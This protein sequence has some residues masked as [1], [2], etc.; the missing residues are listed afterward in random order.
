MTV[1]LEWTQH[2]SHT[3]PQASDAVVTDPSVTA[4]ATVYHNEA[5]HILQNTTARRFLLN[6]KQTETKQHW[7]G[8]RMQGKLACLD[9]ADHSASHSMYKNAAVGE[10]I[11]CFTAKARLQ[12]LPTKYNLAL[13]YPAHHHP[14]CIMHSGHQLESVAHVVNGCTMYKGLYIA[15]HDRLVDLISSNVKEV[16]LENVTMFKHS[17]IMPEWFNSSIDV[18][19]NIPN[20]PDVVFLNRERREVLLLEIGCVFDLYM[21][22]AF[23]DKIL[24]YQPILEILRDLGYQCKLIVFIFGSLGHVH[25]RVFSGL[26]LAGLSSR[27]SKQLAKFCSI[28]A[29]IGSLAVWRRRCFLYP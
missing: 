25:N 2:N 17:R 18:M 14:N 4:E 19:C 8:L 20:T 28:S 15:R 23:N 9:F 12:V 22:M 1:K 7:T 24:K 10:D 21:E 11:L 5:Q 16:S 29:V 13:W 3:A 26:R 6:I 27:K